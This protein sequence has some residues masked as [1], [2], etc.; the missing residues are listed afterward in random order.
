MNIVSREAA[1]ERGL[2]KFCTGVPCS[3]GH[4]A[5]RYVTSG[6]C[7]DCNSRIC[8]QY[9]EANIERVKAVSAAYRAEHRDEL[10]Q[11]KKD[12]YNA[13]KPA[14]REASKRWY[15]A[16]REKQLQYL[17]AWQAANADY[18]R[19][20]KTAYYLKRKQSD[21]QFAVLTRLRRRINHFVSGDN[22]SGKTAE[23]IGCSYEAFARHVEN[24]FTDGMSWDNRSEWHIDHIIP[25]AAFDL[26]DPEQQRQCFHY[27]NMRPLWAHENRRKGASMPEAA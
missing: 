8:R 10:L 7:V 24:Q 18:F 19:Q 16:N 12:Y 23:L 14:R 27:S 21:P 2:A 15:E 26:S 9:R 4:L 25:C 13:N 22:K 1:R 3:H 6:K 20:Q 17:R 5:E 11:K